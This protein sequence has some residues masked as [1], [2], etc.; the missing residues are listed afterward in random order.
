MLV[1]GEAGVDKTTVLEALRRRLTD[2]RWLWGAC[3]GSFTPR[4]RAQPTAWSARRPYQS[5]AAWPHRTNGRRRPRARLRCSQG[6]AR[7]AR[8]PRHA[9]RRSSRTG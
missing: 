1:A 7:T 5:P 4:A 6:R 2:A 3:D 8:R 9:A